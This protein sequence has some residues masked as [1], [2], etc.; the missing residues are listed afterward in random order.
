[1]TPDGCESLLIHLRI[2]RQIKQLCVRTASLHALTK[3]Q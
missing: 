3:L 2:K 1:M